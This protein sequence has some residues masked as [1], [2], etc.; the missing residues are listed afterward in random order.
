M[1][2][3]IYLVI[4]AI[5]LTWQRWQ[6]KDGNDEETVKKP[7]SP[8]LNWEEVEKK[9]IERA[10]GD[11]LTIMDACFAGAVRTMLHREPG[12]T[13]EYLG[14]CAYDK[15]TASPGEKSFTAALINALQILLDE[16]EKQQFTTADLSRVIG[17]QKYRKNNLPCLWSRSA[18]DERRIMLAPMGKGK[19][20]FDNTEIPAYLELR[21]ELKQDSLT[22]AEV[23][24][25][26]RRVARSVS[27]S[28]VKTRRVDWL[29]K[30][31]RPKPSLKSA[32][33]LVLFT[34]R[35]A[36]KQLETIQEEMHMAPMQSVPPLAPITR[37]GFFAT[38][39]VM[40]W[41]LK[42]HMKTFYLLK[43]WTRVVG[44][45][46]LLAALVHFQ[47]FRRSP[48]DLLRAALVKMGPLNRSPG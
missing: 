26:A 14:A 36:K 8:W 5:K 31:S 30:I 7:D 24:D 34:I 3:Y 16:G 22:P 27:E 32:A 28:T 13:Y 33:R 4:T 2:T 21:I 17:L 23:E 35:R 38:F 25:L 29:Q 1:R 6:D 45:G 42:P 46:L 9:F 20:Y 15:T 18:H 44:V 41:N 48:I 11:V 37:P 12:H 39:G 10:K 40:D 19:P 43:P 47:R